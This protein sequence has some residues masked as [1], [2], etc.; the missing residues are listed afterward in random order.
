MCDCIYYYFST[1]YEVLCV[2]DGSVMDVRI[3]NECERER[4]SIF[5]F[6]RRK[7]ATPEYILRFSNPQ[8][9]IPYPVTFFS[10]L[11]H[12]VIAYFKDSR[13]CMC[14]CVDGLVHHRKEMSHIKSFI[15]T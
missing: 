11:F 9:T 13:E 7:L 6:I 2:G 4:E 12:L 10:N 1:G 8:R 3:K 14:V 5:I 15:E